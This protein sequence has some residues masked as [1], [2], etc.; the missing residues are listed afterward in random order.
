[1]RGAPRRGGVDEPGGADELLDHLSRVPVLVGSRRRGHEDGLGG[2]PL[3]LVEPQRPV[4]ERG[5]EPEPVLDQGLLARA[6]AAVHAP[7][8]R[9]GH[10]AF[11]DEEQRIGREVVEQ[12]RRRLAGAAA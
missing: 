4:V 10:V 3:E 1:M 8:L 11:V 12:G 7:E 2:E 6:V 5:R 9:H